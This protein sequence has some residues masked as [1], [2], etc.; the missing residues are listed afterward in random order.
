MKVLIFLVFLTNLVFAKDIT[1][2][3]ENTAV[4]RGPV[5]SSSV[6]EVMVQLSELDRSGSDKEP[7]YLVL[8]TPGGSVMDGLNLIE[9]M[10]SLRRPVHSISI[11]AASMGFHILQNSEKRYITK[12]GTIMSH[13]ASGGFNGDIPQQVKSRFKHITD[14]LEKMDEQVVSRTNG[15]YNKQSYS[16]LIRDEYWAV[17]S[18]AIK[19]GFV[20]DVAKAKCDA[21]LSGSTQK[22][23]LTFFGTVVVTFSNCPLITEPLSVEKETQAKLKEYLTGIRNLEF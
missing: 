4:L 14:L 13:R 5:N 12:Y 6:A 23:L 11:F 16:E 18:N 8:D 10:T 21:S 7:I 22:T 9:Y 19:E 15:K 2:T 3:K 17:G 1:L 20:D